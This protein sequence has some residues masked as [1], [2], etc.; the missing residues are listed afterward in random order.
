MRPF[1]FPFDFQSGTHSQD[2]EVSHAD[3]IRAALRMRSWQLET[4]AEAA[5]QL[6]AAGILTAYRQEVDSRQ[7]AQLHPATRDSQARMSC[8]PSTPVG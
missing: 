6:N 3:R 1:D 2:P 5:G 7:S 4:Y 8:R